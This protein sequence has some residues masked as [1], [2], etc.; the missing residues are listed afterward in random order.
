MIAHD[1]VARAV[2]GDPADPVG[3]PDPVA[4][5]LDSGVTFDPAVTDDP[6][7]STAPDPSGSRLGLAP[8]AWFPSSSPSSA[9]SVSAGATPVAFHHR[10]SLIKRLSEPPPCKPH[11]TGPGSNKRPSRPPPYGPNET[12]HGRREPTIWCGPTKWYSAARVPTIRTGRPW[13]NYQAN[14]DVNS[15]SVTACQLHVVFPSRTSVTTAQGRRPQQSLKDDDVTSRKT[16]ATTS[17]RKPD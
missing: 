10:F 9:V 16:S 5:V 7:T 14:P 3:T 4:T 6:V 12:A 8:A 11:E 2:P 17:N 13:S 15:Q 1:P